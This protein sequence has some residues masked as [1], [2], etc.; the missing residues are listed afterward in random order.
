MKK[1]AILMLFSLL[2]GPIYAQN[3]PT[4]IIEMFTNKYCPNCPPA[5]KKL[6]QIAA[7]NQNLIV[8]FAHVGYWDTPTRQDPFSL[9]EATERQYDYSNT[10]GP[11]PGQVF[12]PMPVLNGQFVANPPLFFNWSSTLK[13][14]QAA[15]ALQKIGVTQAASGALSLNIPTE[16]AKKQNEI[17]ILGL[18]PANSTRP[19]AYHLTG[20]QQYEI[21]GPQTSISANLAPKTKPFLV[22]VQQKGPGS[23]LAQALVE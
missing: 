21:T 13:Q 11:R 18:K 19:T 8:V 6:S 1:F 22:L 7:E 23:L 16:I 5:E 10:L 4:I 15:P 9:P 2:C 3:S 12:T 17:W 20:V 14:A